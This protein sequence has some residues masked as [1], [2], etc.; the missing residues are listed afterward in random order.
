VK[1]GK[2]F[3]SLSPL[4]GGGERE[5]QGGPLGSVTGT[6]VKPTCEQAVCARFSLPRVAD[7]W[8]WGQYFKVV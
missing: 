7:V 8:A 2:Y 6:S 3:R 5:G 4:I 1:G